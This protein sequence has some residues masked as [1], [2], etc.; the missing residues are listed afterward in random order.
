MSLQTLLSL[1]LTAATTSNIESPMTWKPAAVPIS[2]RWAQAVDPTNPLP[3]YPRPQLVRPEWK[4]LN[5]LWDYALVK[6]DAPRPDEWQGRILVPFAIE[7][8]LSGV[9]KRV[10]RDEA[11]W[12]WRSFESQKPSGRMLLHFGAVDWKCEAWVN[13]VAVGTH[14]GGFDPFTFDI[15]DALKAGTN[16]LVIKVLDPTDDAA[17]P[18]GKQVREPNG[19]WYTPVSGIW[20]TV[21]LEPVPATSIAGL[22]I[23][24]DLDRGVVRVEVARRGGGAPVEATI[25][26]LDG[27]NVVASANGKTGEPIDIPIRSAKTWSPDSPF[28][29]D[30][31]VTLPGSADAVTSYFGIRKVSHALDAAGYQRLM[32]NNKPIF[33]FGPLDQGWWPDGLYTAPTD[34]ALRYDI[35]ITKRFGFNMARKHIKLEPARWY[36]W[37]DKLG[38]MVW[39]DMPSGGVTQRIKE[40]YVDRNAPDANIND[41]ESA[42]F[43]L[44]LRSIIDAAYNAPSIVVWVPFNEGWFQHRTNEILKWTKAYDPTRLVDGPSGWDDRG[45]GDLHDEHRYPGPDMLVADGKRVSVL[46]EYGGLGLPIEG[47]VWQ[48]K[49]NWGYVTYNGLDQLQSEYRDLTA[50]LPALVKRGLAAAVYTQTTDVEIEVNGL[51]TYD[52]KVIKFDPQELSR[53]HA[54]VMAALN[55]PVRARVLVPINRQQRSEY[56]YVTE[57]PAERWAMLEFDASQWPSIK[58]N[59]GTKGKGG[60]NVAEPYWT[61]PQLWA[62]RTTTLDTLP[63]GEVYVRA[64]H[65]QDTDIYLNGVLAASLKGDVSDYVEVKISDEA[66]AALRVGDNVIGIHAR[67]KGDRRIIDVGLLDITP[68]GR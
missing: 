31:K 40:Y 30:L 23:T 20:Q 16:E 12:Y 26:V 14:E 17:Q 4:N 43:Q 1:V 35:E 51:L 61:T 41:A 44:E 7:S 66:R 37:C 5:G 28:L 65:D 34:D 18:R 48:D 47:H 38:L 39:Q 9:G 50:R 58:G 21:W 27:D 68:V 36:Y 56:R 32:L 67:A 29:Y 53:L 57:P 3:E 2:T 63:S 62:R 6:H 46:G 55:E 19:I 33:M 45:F 54:N 10:A 24:P 8:S 22:K 13:G 59:I 25:D 42:V 49:K 60:F 11:L 15:T 52:R 64:V